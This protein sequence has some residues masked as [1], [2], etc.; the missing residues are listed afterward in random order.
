MRRRASLTPS[1]DSN[2]KQGSMPSAKGSFSR[3]SISRRRRYSARLWLRITLPATATSH[4][5]GRWTESS[6]SNLRQATTYTSERTSCASCALS[7]RL[8]QY[9]KTSARVCRYRYSK[10]SSSRIDDRRFII[11]QSRQ[12][13]HCLWLV[14]VVRPTHRGGHTAL[15]WPTRRVQHRRLRFREA[16]DS[17]L[18]RSSDRTGRLIPCHESA[19]RRVRGS[20][21]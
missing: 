15:S 10:S 6:S 5:M 8:R 21:S 7:T 9:D 13:C 12:A 20:S 16:R 17:G 18:V 14:A 3:R 4:A 19:V 1:L 11:A 2:T